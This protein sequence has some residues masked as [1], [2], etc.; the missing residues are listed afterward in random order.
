MII[1]ANIIKTQGLLSPI[2]IYFHII[3][4]CEVI[5]RYIYFVGKAFLMI[6]CSSPSIDLQ[7]ITSHS[8]TYCEETKMNLGVNIYSTEI[9][10]Y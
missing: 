7:S 4:G 1:K 8:M 5:Y 6:Q 3:C 2:S 9:Y 10:K